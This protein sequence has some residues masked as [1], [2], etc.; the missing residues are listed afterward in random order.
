[1]TI[2][3]GHRVTYQGYEAKVYLVTERQIVLDFPYPYNGNSRLTLGAT[4]PEVVVSLEEDTEED[5]V[6]RGPKP[7]LT[8]EQQKAAAQALREGT[9]TEAELAR[10]HNVDRST[11]NRIAHRNDG[12]LLAGLT[13]TQQREIRSRR[14]V[15]D[16]KE[17][18]IR[19]SSPTHQELADEYGVSKATINTILN[20]WQDDEDARIEPEPPSS[21]ETPKETVEGALEEVADAVETYIAQAPS[22]EEAKHFPELLVDL[23][24]GAKGEASELRKFVAAANERILVL[25]ELVPH[26]EAVLAFYAR[27]DAFTWYESIPERFRDESNDLK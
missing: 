15:G 14:F 12:P 24:E 2:K 23:L 19:E 20:H 21:P 8:E 9:K 11:I 26:L 22:Y 5:D 13:Q 25:S 18:R 7:K 17:G 27:D 1:M 3:A 10:E 6:K 4:W 16:P